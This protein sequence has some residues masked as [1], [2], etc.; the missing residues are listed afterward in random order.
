MLAVIKTG[1]K[2]YLVDE[3]AKIKVEKLDK[4]ENK[5]VT[6]NQ[7]LLLI[8][9]KG[10]VQFGTPFIKG[11]KVQAKIIKQA[12]Y[13]KVTIIKH[14]PKK[15]YRVKKGHKQPFSQIQITKIS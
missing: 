6:I 2:Q 9:E 13:P 15:R 8:N 3:N 12:R 4:P 10:K 11:A 14:R 5:T 1:G 7:V